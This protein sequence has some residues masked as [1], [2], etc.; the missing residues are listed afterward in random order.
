MLRKFPPNSDS[1]SKEDYLKTQAE[2]IKA[3]YGSFKAKEI[4]AKVNKVQ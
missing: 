2:R 4:A 3:E 1:Q